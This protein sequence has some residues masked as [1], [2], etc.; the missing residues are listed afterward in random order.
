MEED[1]M[2][3]QFRGKYKFLSNFYLCNISY[4]N[5]VFGSSEHLFHA[6]KSLDMDYIR[7]LV[8]TEAPYDAKRLGRSVKLRPD[9]EEI[10]D[11]WMLFVQEMKYQ[12]HPDLREKLINTYQHD[13]V[14]GN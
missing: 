1:N 7:S 8:N 9:W 5:F 13:L 3:K 10:K 2:I 11:N 6:G 12:Q 4:M 14:E